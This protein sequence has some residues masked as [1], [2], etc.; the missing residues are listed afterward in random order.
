MTIK[1]R[2]GPPMQ[3][4]GWRGWAPGLSTHAQWLDW[5]S[6]G[7]GNPDGEHAPAATCAPPRLR[8]RCSFLTKMV[9]E[10]MTGP[11][12]S[13]GIAPR[14]PH[15]IYASRNGE[16][17]TLERL[18][19]ELSRQEPPSPTWFQNS[20][21][22]TPAAYLS[23]VTE[24]RRLSRTLSAGKDTFAAS[25][26]EAAH[27]LTQRPNDRVL[28]VNAEER[29]PVP[30]DRLLRVPPFP[31]AVT[32]LVEQA[33]SRGAEPCRSHCLELWAGKE[34]EGQGR[35]EEEPVMAFLRWLVGT[36]RRHQLNTGFGALTWQRG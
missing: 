32:F 2:L 12:E 15:L 16:I 8:R 14:E 3:I 36:R 25:F 19:S 35:E 22:H 28:L 27:L 24:N 23:L 9:L 21:H 31:F 20:V 34:G 7:N 4:R 30:F 6:T 26:L 18:F 17:Q 10:T 11:C 13:A 29:V 33:G 5:L 1:K